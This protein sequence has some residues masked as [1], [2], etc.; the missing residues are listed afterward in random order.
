MLNIKSWVLHYFTSLSSKSY[1]KKANISTSF[2]ET[3]CFRTI[4][5]SKSLINK[6]HYSIFCAI[7]S[8]KLPLGKPYFIFLKLTGRVCVC[9]PLLFQIPVAEVC[10]VYGPPAFLVK[11]VWWKHRSSALFTYC[12]CAQRHNWEKPWQRLCVLQSL[13]YL[14]SGPL[15]T[16][17]Q[18]LLS[19]T[20]VKSVKVKFSPY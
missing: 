2:L 18:P 20:L 10:L 19:G 3:I 4:I 1:A 5:Q 16:V 17:C 15:Q 7:A 9:L 14:L 11:E 6:V 12:L 8:L 13:K